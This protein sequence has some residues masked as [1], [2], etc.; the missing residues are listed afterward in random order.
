M[1]CRLELGDVAGADADL[2][3]ADTAAARLRQPANVAQVAWYRAMRAE[4][5]GRYDDA[6][7]LSTEALALHQRTGL[8]GAWECFATQLFTLRRSQGRIIELEP[9]LRQLAETSDF[10]GFREAQA[11]MYLDLGRPDDARASLGDRASF[12]RMPQDWS[13]EF[14]SC[15]QAEVC[16]ELGDDDARR[17]LRDDLLPYADLLAMIGTGVGCWGPI[18]Y[19]VGRLEE[20][21]RNDDEA[22]RRYDQAI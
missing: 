21:L 17:R 19:F 16:A 7:R 2:E 4:L 18:S 13:F 10:V 22:L 9:L 15:V 5:S 3:V 1:V 8:W 20:A 6:E 11:L 14:L 12:P